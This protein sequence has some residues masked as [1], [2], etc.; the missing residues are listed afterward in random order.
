MS[1]VFAFPA[2]RSVPVA[3]SDFFD[4]AELQAY[5]MRNAAHHPERVHNMK[6]KLQ[7]AT[8]TAGLLYNL[9]EAIRLD[10]NMD[11]IERR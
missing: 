9:V 1:N 7:L 10:L 3:R 5:V 2:L 4:E 11:E 8:K 6:L